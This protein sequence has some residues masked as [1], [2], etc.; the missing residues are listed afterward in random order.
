MPKYPETGGSSETQASGVLR[1]LVVE[2]HPDTRQGIRTFLEAL[3]YRAVLA[4]DKAQA[5]ALAGEQTFDVLLSDISLPDGTGWELLQALK[6]QARQPKHAIAM[7]GLSDPADQTRSREAGFEIHLVKPFRPEE[8]ENALLHASACPARTDE[9]AIPL[10]ATFSTGGLRQTL[11]DGLSQHLVAAGL[12][13]GALVNHL[14]QV[15]A[16]AADPTVALTRAVQ[17]SR[18][19]SRLIDE[20]LEDVLALM[21]SL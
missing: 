9:P 7:S 20:A 18:Q 3:G 4:E 14:E 16:T 5:L 19:I 15:I 2:N 11:H 1:V 13:Q 17:E 12:L 8:L 6:V 10:A 21:R